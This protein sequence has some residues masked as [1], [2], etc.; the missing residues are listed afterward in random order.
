MFITGFLDLRIN[1][2]VYEGGD[3]RS[4]PTL[5][6]FG[7]VILDVFLENQRGAKYKIFLLKD[8][9]FAKIINFNIIYGML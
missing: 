2:L 3:R 8:I 7:S 1:L 4:V 5:E 9:F 6:S